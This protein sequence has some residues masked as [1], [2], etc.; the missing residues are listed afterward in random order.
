MTGT[1]GDIIAI[2][3]VPV[4]ILAFWLVM[5]FYAGSHPLWRGQATPDAIS[6]PALPDSVP[7]ER[8]SSPGPVVPGQRL[9]TAA[10][11]VT[12]EQAG[13]SETRR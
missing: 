13:P 11:D 1:T 8:L 5:M 6:T 2:V 9:G 3:I 7:A 10:G 4:V 12:P